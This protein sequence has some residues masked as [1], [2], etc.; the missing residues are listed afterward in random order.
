M[1][2]RFLLAL[3]LVLIVLGHEAQGALLPQTEPFAS[4][5][6]LVQVQ[7]SLST[8]WDT[9]KA[10]AQ[11]LYEKTYLPSVDEKLRDMYSKGSAA[12]TTYAGI[13]TDQLLTM[14][15]GD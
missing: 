1:G 11:G 10:A 9:A 3:F 15:K 4:P 8:Y 12:I 7:E 5:T 6:L 13:F 14:L 2:L